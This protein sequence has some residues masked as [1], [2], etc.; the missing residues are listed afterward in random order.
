MPLD[1]LIS[2]L[3]GSSSLHLAYDALRKNHHTSAQRYC[4]HWTGHTDTQRQNKIKNVAPVYLTVATT[5]I[6]NAEKFSCERARM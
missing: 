3:V 5:H 2:F 6:E 1:W 4:S